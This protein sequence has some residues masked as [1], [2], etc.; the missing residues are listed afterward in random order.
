MSDAAPKPLRFDDFE[1]DEQNALLSRAGRPIALPPKAFAVLCELARQPG[2]LIRKDDLLDGVWGH[3]HV[4]ESVLKTT[5]SQVRAALSDDPAKPRYIQTASRRGYRFVARITTA[6]APGVSPLSTLTASESGVEMIG[7]TAALTRLHDAWRDVVA[8]RHRIVWIAG[9]PGIGKTT[10]VER[11]VRDLGDAL[12]VRGHCVEQY[13]AGEPYLPMLEAL[14]ALCRKRPELAARMRTIAPTWLVQLPWLLNDGE[15]VALHG[16]LAGANQERKIREL[17]ELMTQFT[18]EHPLVIITEDLH[19]SDNATLRLVD[20]FARRTTLA[21]VMWLATFRLTQVIAEGHP[22]QELRQ[23]L[24]L[25]R[26]CEEIGLDPFSE[27]EVAEY[28][29]RRTPQAH[30][31]EAFVHRLHDHTGGLPLFVVNVVDHLAAQGLGAFND[32]G[33]RGA[34]ASWSAPEHLRAAIEKQIARLSS[35]QQRLLEAASVC[36]MEFRAHTLGHVL[37]QDAEAVA[38]ACDELAQRQYWLQHLGVVDLPDGSLDARYAFRHALYRH[39]FYE[40]QGAT[41]RVHLHRRVARSLE[42]ARAAGA[43]IKWSE[44]AS[45]HE[46]GLEHAAALR[47]Y[48]EAARHALANFAPRAAIDLTAHARELLSRIPDGVERDELEFALTAARGVACSQQFGLASSEA[49]QAYQRA[50]VL[51]DQLPPTPARAHVLAG[52]AWMYYIRGEYRESQRL[53]ERMRAQAEETPD[54]VSLLSACVVL[55]VIANVQARFPEAHDYFERGMQ[56]CEQLGDRAPSGAFVADPLVVLRVNAAMGLMHMGL[57]DRARREMDS[58]LTRAQQRGQLMA[59]TIALWCAAMFEMRMERPQVVAEYASALRK[60]VVDSALTQA[61]GPSRWILGWATAHLGSPQEGAR[62]IREG[63]EFNRNLGMVS[64]GA[65][66]LG[67]AVEALTLARDWDAAQAQLD[68]AGVLARGLG[69]RI[70][71]P[72]LH[73]RQSHIDVGRGDL[74]AARASLAAG[75]EAAR[76]QGSIWM[77]LRMLVLLCELPTAGAEDRVV[78][79][80]VYERLT[81]GFDVPLVRRAAKLLSAR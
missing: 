57:L 26:L 36:G 5:I 77:E 52:L 32:A 39:V 62:L 65:E 45:Q 18:A 48:A 20:Y 33:P 49:E 70:L 16:E 15:R 42:I 37:D 55:G 51:C 2:K 6:A 76:E 22:L 4:S 40:R 23:E 13:G 68:E 3:R 66:V 79:K 25:H 7:R 75:I 64:G 71:F 10:L 11:F 53:A 43:A 17:A 12:I 67:Y 72:Y 46:S 21:R 19:W 59:R 31:T 74:D 24:R 47:C 56:L 14:G 60:L 73:L 54:A 63:F 9:D 58:A 50:L 30:V 44:L 8:G 1:L 78:L 35:P 80:R 28:L 29:K 61:E 81:E 41:T 34:R 38:T 27:V 69:E